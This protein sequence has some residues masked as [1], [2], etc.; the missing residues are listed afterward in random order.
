ML[1]KLLLRSQSCRLCSFRKM[2]SP[3]KYRPFLACF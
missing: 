2:R 1:W 3:P